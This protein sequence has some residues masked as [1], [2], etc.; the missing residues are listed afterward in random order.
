M[1]RRDI[2]NDH[3]SPNFSVTFLL[4]GALIASNCLVSPLPGKLF[5]DLNN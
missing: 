5:L 1:N 3:H 4:G 2:N